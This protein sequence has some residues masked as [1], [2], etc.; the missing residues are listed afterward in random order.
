MDVSTSHQPNTSI[1]NA[2]INIVGRSIFLTLCFLATLT[3]KVLSARVISKLFIV[4]SSQSGLPSYSRSFQV[5]YSSQLPMSKFSLLDFVPEV[6]YQYSSL[7]PKLGTFALL[8][9]TGLHRIHF[10]ILAQIC[11]ILNCYRHRD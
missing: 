8:V 10:K 3:N 6:E 7:S 11:Q 9:S 5:T 1:P 2:P 4:S